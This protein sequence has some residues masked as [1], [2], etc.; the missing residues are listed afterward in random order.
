MS[1]KQ[2]RIERAR[3]V[4]RRLLRDR[5]SGDD[6]DDFAC[7]LLAYEGEHPSVFQFA[8]MQEMLEERTAQL[9]AV[10]TVET[11]DGETTGVC[12]GCLNCE[13]DDET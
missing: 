9:E 13:D 6:V 11:C 10:K 5:L 1:E 8:H 4:A 2:D 7:A 3:E 12:S